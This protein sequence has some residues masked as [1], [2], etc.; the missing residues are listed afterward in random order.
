MQNVCIKENSFFKDNFYSLS[1]ATK[2]EG[3]TKGSHVFGHYIHIFCF[4]CLQNDDMAYGRAA[5]LFIKW[6]SYF[7]G[8]VH[9]S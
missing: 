2:K 7:V 4:L 6:N 5:D 3:T 8:N 9:P 1:V